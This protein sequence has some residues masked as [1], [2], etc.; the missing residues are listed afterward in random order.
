MVMHFLSL[1]SV[2][3]L[4][5]S[6]AERAGC[7]LKDAECLDEEQVFF[8]L[9]DPERN[10][11]RTCSS[12]R[13]FP[14]PPTVR[15][16]VGGVATVATI[17]TIHIVPP[18][19]P[20]PP[21]VP[22]AVPVPGTRPSQFAKSRSQLLNRTTELLLDAVDDVVAELSFSSAVPLTGNLTIS[23]ETPDNQSQQLGVADTP[24]VFEF[25]GN[26]F[27]GAVAF[28]VWKFTLL[29]SASSEPRIPYGQCGWTLDELTWGMVKRWV[30]QPTAK[31]CQ[32][33]VS[34]GFCKALCK[35]GTRYIFKEQ[36][37]HTWTEFWLVGLGD[38]KEK[39]FI[40]Q[41]KWIGKNVCWKSAT[42]F[43]VKREVDYKDEF[44]VRNSEAFCKA[45]TIYQK[46]KLIL[47][48]EFWLVRVRV[49]FQDKSWS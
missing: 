46:R 42:F 27:P 45:G 22:L 44:I 32:M 18:A 15:A 3:L 2:L 21:P 11:K 20:A 16:G 41:G 9:C 38:F 8:Q 28:G 23:L 24:V 19:L 1:L 13:T 6:E 7:D 33:S 36:V 25:E 17:A 40:I 5:T 49:L 37:N 10:W 47:W 31:G 34:E 35:A 48:T 12:N 4:L 29:A 43:A 14:R 30:P 26:S 39:L